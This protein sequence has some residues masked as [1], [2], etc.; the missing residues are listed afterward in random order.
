[1]ELAKRDIK[2]NRQWRALLAATGA[3][4]AEDHPEPAEGA[5]KWIHEIRQEPVKWHAKVQ[6]HREAE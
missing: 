6:R 2:L 3:W 5:A 1:M 4:E